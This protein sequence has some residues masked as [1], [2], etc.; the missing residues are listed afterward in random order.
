MMEIV[1]E[2]LDGLILTES[3]IY[4]DNNFDDNDDDDDDVGELTKKPKRVWHW[5]GRLFMN[6]F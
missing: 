4:Q 5:Q 6:W 2:A 3:A 1:I